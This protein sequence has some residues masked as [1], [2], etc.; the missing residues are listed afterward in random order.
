MSSR[1]SV[2][3]TRRRA[4]AAHSAATRDRVHTLTRAIE[5]TNRRLD[6]CASSMSIHHTTADTIGDPATSVDVSSHRRRCFDS[7]ASV[8]IHLCMQL[9]DHRS[10]MAVARC[11]RRMMSEGNDPFAWKDAAPF[12]VDSDRVAA[13]DA[14]LIDRSLIRLAG[15]ALR[16]RRR[17]QVGFV[18]VAALPHLRGLRVGAAAASLEAH[19]WSGLL[20]SP[21][22]H[23]LRSLHFGHQLQLPVEA[24]R[25]ATSLPHLHTLS[26]HYPYSA[27]NDLLATLPSAPALTD[28]S[29]T[30]DCAAPHSVIDPVGQ[31]AGL[32]SLRLSCASFAPGQFASL[33]CS[34]PL[35]GL[36]SLRLH[37]FSARTPMPLVRHTPPTASEYAA[38]FSTLTALD[39]L[40]LEGVFGINSLLEHVVHAR[41]L[42]LIE[43]THM[44]PE[45]ATHRQVQA[46]G[47]QS[48]STAVV[49]TLL[50]ANPQLRIVL[51]ASS[52]LPQWLAQGRRS[53]AAA[54]ADYERQW[55]SLQSD[56]ADDS[57]V[58]LVDDEEIGVADDSDSDS[59]SSDTDEGG[60]EGDVEH[61]D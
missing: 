15:L 32:R 38:V 60:D 21:A 55:R 44:Q 13:V 6:S 27:P 14:A 7:L 23:S 3:E 20:A 54:L 2:A 45:S 19:E 4:L 28:L 18:E 5:R 47:A 59:D 12:H 17:G 1:V 8:E 58:S 46:Y 57:R 61:G 25:D 36:R 51:H 39:H 35:H 48:P 34:P 31:C 16:W 56:W 52:S 22:L 10:R 41:S 30:V 49:R 29:L 26:L 40:G 50:A 42:R 33:L 9:L 53:S 37:V 11:S 43:V 24:V